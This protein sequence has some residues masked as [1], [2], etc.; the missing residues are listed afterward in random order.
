MAG[1]LSNPTIGVGGIN[2]C[3]H[4]SIPSWVG[5][6]QLV[7]F[8]SFVNLL[9]LNYLRVGS[10]ERMS[11]VGNDVFWCSPVNS[12]RCF[13]G[14]SSRTLLSPLLVL[15]FEWW[16]P[17]Q[18]LLLFYL[19]NI[20]G[21][22]SWSRLPYQRIQPTHLHHIK[23]RCRDWVSLILLLNVKGVTDSLIVIV[24]GDCSE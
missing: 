3:W 15:I 18:V 17:H 5:D 9:T 4:T 21:P 13:L 12:A 6:F 11:V 16:C 20:R 14:V 22:C 7:E 1:D 19:G 8:S 24:K 2:L 10:E 23:G